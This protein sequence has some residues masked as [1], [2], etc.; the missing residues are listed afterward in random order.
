MTKK[1]LKQELK[2][3]QKGNRRRRKSLLMHHRTDEGKKAHSRMLNFVSKRPEGFRRGE[4]KLRNLRLGIDASNKINEIADKLECTFS[5]VV[6]R[7][8]LE[9]GD[10]LSIQTKTGE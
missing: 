3:A 7:C 8:V 4:T 1:T 2:K 5:H 9:Y 10:T 6:E